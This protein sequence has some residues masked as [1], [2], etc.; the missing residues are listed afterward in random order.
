[1]IFLMQK[2]ASAKSYADQVD[3]R[4]SEYGKIG[5]QRNYDQV[6]I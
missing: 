4:A 3:M 6:K 2:E 5:L 1:M